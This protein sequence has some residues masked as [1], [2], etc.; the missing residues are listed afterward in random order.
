VPLLVESGTWRSRV[1]RL[2]VIDCST[3]TQEV[4]VRSRSG[5]DGVM[6]RSIIAQQ[7]TRAERL[8][9]ADDVLVNEGRMTDLGPRV[10][11]L[12]RRYCWLASAAARTL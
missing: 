12:H 1:D 3:A 2:L 9:A 7:A 8:D 5:L 4:R 6:T 10:A 11:R